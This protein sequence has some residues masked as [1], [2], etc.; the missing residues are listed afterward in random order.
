MTL[1]YLE[2]T[3]ALT[4]LS[5]AVANQ[6]AKYAQIQILPSEVEIAISSYGILTLKAR[7]QSQAT[8]TVLNELCTVLAPVM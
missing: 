2:K 5:A 1:A 8:V 3:D 6:Q 7:N 4:I